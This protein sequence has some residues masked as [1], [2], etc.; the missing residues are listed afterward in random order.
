MRDTLICIIILDMNIQ[1]ISFVRTCDRLIAMIT[2]RRVI[3]A[4][5]FFEISIRVLKRG[6]GSSLAPSK[7]IIV[8]F[9]FFY[10]IVSTQIS[11]SR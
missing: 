4:D 2:D 5:T 8:Y 7:K 10:P 6:F 3:S 9:Y 11:T 1:T